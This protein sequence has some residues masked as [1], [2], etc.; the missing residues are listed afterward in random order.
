MGFQSCGSPN[1]ENFGILGNFETPNL[2]VL[3][4]ND[5]WVLALWPCIKNT[6]GEGGDFSQ[7]Q[8][9]VSF[10]GTCLRM[11]CPC[12]KGAPTMC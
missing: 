11:V 6:K 10:V 8:A 1:F 9:G 2:G 3:G 5:I 12:T 4:Q 7:V